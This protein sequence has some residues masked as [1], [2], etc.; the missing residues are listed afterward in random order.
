M[1]EPL[2][3]PLAAY[4]GGSRA[5][6]LGNA[7]SDVD[8]TV[9]AADPSGAPRELDLQSGDVFLHCQVTTLDA[10]APLAGLF[11]P[12]ALPVE[13]ASVT[14]DAVVSA[15]R[16]ATELV[17]GTYVATSPEVD[18]LRA[19]FDVARLDRLSAA[20]AAMLAALSVRDAAGAARSG[21]ALTE[22]AAAEIA[23]EYAL[24]AALFAAGDPYR[25]RKF[26]PRRLA[27]HP[28]LVPYLERL[29]GGDA[30]ETL[31]LANGLAAATLLGIGH[32]WTYERHDGGPARSPYASLVATDAGLRLAGAVE[33]ALARPTALVWLLADGRPVDDVAKRFQE[34]TGVDD[35]AAFVGQAFDALGANAA[36]QA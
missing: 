6:G 30:T 22:R 29:R 32:A 34:L 16:R 31:L 18:A 7:L 24:D 26:L 2:G 10:L 12:D 13:T 20:A 27:R 28:H 14:A 36:L 35:A 23:L 9:V 15:H 5:F 3:P 25:S 33:L 11:A 21:D 19:R 8:L 17:R 4:L 1:L